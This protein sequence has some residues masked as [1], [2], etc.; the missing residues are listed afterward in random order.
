M[1]GKVGVPAAP[2]GI[3][4]KRANRSWLELVQG[5]EVGTTVADA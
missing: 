5:T 4:W 2:K 3:S 1:F